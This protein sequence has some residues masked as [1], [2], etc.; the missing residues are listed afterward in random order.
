MNLARDPV[1]VPPFYTRLMA[2]RRLLLL[3]GLAVLSLLL[4]ADVLI[5]PA[6]LGI[7]EVII[8]LFNPASVDQAIRVIV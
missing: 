7:D 5:G 6:L 3:V 2:R 4:I 8:A 1:M